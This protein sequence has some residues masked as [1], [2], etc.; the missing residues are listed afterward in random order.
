MKRRPIGTPLSRR[1]IAKLRTPALGQILCP[2]RE[3]EG[4]PVPGVF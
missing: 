3:G 2:L 4:L 1:G